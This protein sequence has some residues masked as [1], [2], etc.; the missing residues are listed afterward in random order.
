MSRKTWK[1]HLRPFEM[2]VYKAN[3]LAVALSASD[4]KSAIAACDKAG[5]TNCSWAAYEAANSFRSLLQKQ[6]RFRQF[7]KRRATKKEKKS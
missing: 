2:L 1:D 6:L 3:S 7:T 4:L 5:Q